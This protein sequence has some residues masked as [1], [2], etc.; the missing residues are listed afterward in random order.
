MYVM[1]N[2][3]ALLY[4]F[5]G[6]RKMDVTFGRQTTLSRYASDRHD[7]SFRARVTHES[8]EVVAVSVPGLVCH[9]SSG[10]TTTTGTINYR[11]VQNPMKMS[12]I[13]F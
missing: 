9:Q 6:R 5:S 7:R 3:V 12:D 4:A 13:V 8:C 10:T 11:G 2:L 1:C